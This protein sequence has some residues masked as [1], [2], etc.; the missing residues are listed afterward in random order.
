MLT[1]TAGLAL[2]FEELYVDNTVVTKDSALAFIKQQPAMFEPGAR[3]GYSNVGYYLLGKIIE[4]VSGL[5]F[6]TYLQRNILDVAGMADTGLNSNTALVP[7]LA[8]LYCREGDTLVKNP[9][10]N[11]NL[12]VGHDGLYSTAGDLAK[13]AQALQGTKLLSEASKALMVTQHNKRYSGIGFWDRY[14]YGVFVDPYYNHGHHLLTHS[15][16]YFGAMTTLDRY[17]KDG[18]LVTVLSNNQ[19]DSA[20]MAYGLAGILFG[21]A[22]ELPYVHRP[23]PG[24]PA[25]P[26]AYA[27]CYGETS[28]LRVNGQLYLQNLET[29]LVAESANRFFTQNNPD[30]TV[31]FS[32]TKAGRV[33]AIGFTKGG[34]KDIFTKQRSAGRR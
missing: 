13:F 20:W 11:W 1:H 25:A 23:L 30:Q 5:S 22:V 7:R 29:P 6:G 34:V 2:D 15:G 27:G 14:G 8:R 33:S 17:P 4:R 32:L 10:I 26:L 3:V 16:G 21:K 19:G 12:D 28:I 24:A 31:E 18:I 9:T